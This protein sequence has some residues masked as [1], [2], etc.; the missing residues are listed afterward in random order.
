MSPP[1]D[2][3]NAD[4]WRF[5]TRA[6]VALRQ[7]GD[8]V[9]VYVGDRAST[10][11]LSAAAGGAL[12]GLID[13]GEALSVDA[14]FTNAFGDS[15]GAAMSCTERTALLAVLVEFAQLGIAVRVPGAGSAGGADEAGVTSTAA[16]AG[17]S[18]LL[19]PKAS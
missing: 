16:T 5:N 15:G 12:L 3:V 14:L 10:H 17:R 7:W 2:P 4:C 19:E 18:P 1:A 6:G 9:V 8:D 13:S 11:L